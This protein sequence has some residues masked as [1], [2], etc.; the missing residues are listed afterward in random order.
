MIPR[1]VVHQA[2]L[3]MKLSRQEYWSR[4]PFPFLVDLPHP[5][6]EP[7]SLALQADSLSSALLGNPFRNKV[8]N[9]LNAFGSSLN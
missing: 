1:T 4:L 3:S 5:G 8:N 2:P 7:G 6:I 9:K